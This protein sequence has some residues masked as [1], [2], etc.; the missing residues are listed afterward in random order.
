MPLL[1]DNPTHSDTHFNI[2]SSQ[3]DSM[4]PTTRFQPRTLLGAGSNEREMLGQLYA[5]QIASMITSK[6]P[7][8]SRT[9]LL[10]LGLA[11]VE[12]DRDTFLETL[13]LVLEIL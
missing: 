9:L 7:E 4:L 11:K 10:G 12:M 3:E 8:E 6:T 2:E 1:S 5:S 13:N